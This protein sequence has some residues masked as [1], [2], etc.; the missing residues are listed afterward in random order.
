[1]T[2]RPLLALAYLGI[3]AVLFAAA[4]VLTEYSDGARVAVR[5]ISWAGG[6]VLECA[7]LALI[8]PFV[9]AAYLALKE[10]RS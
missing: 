1:M 3:A 5:V 8:Y 2:R 10:P 9:K 4:A 6:A 7:L